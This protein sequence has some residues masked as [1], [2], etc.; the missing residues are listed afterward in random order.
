M[1]TYTIGLLISG[2]LGL[3]CLKSI[4]QRNQIL[5]VLT[6][7]KSLAII[8]YCIEKNIPFYKGNPRDGG[9][10][11]FIKNYKVDMIISIN[12][13]FIIG[14][15]IIN[16]PQKCAINIHGSLLPKYRGRTP[17]VWAI[18]NNETQSGISVHY[19]SESCDSGDIIYQEKIDIDNK[20]TGWELLRIFSERYPII[21]NK[22]INE[23]EK[24]EVISFKQETELATYFGKRTPNDGLIDWNWQKE[25][26][27]NWIRAQAKPYPG[28][29]TFH[30]GEKVIINKVVFSNLGFDEKDINGLVLMGGNNPIIK[31]P[32]GAL[33][34]LSMEVTNIISINKGDILCKI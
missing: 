19:I 34:I 29:F 9:A 22:V 13:L 7:A 28:A 18:I 5:F 24:G 4:I 3:I 6:D 8:E 23:F 17:H 31:T 26:I 30:N 27:Y 25:R 16:F 11:S 12:Y 2:D 33:Q 1:R 32:N 21:I 14:A 20:I 15:N 10:Y